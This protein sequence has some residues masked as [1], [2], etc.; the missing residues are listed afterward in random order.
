MKKVFQA[1]GGLLIAIVLCV[2]TFAQ[3]QA[4]TGLIQGT[5]V[6]PNGAVVQGATVTVKNTGTGFERSATSN[7]D[8]FFSLPLLPLGKYRVTTEAANFSKAVVEGLEVNVGQTTNLKIEL[9][10]GG[11]TQTVDIRAEGEGVEIS[12][13]ELN[14]LINEKSVEGLPINR[15]DFSRFAQLTP[16]VSIVQGPDGDEIT[17]NGQKG[18]Q[19]NLSIDGADAN[20]PFFGEQ[21]GGQRPAFTISLES[22][23]EFQVVPVGA[24]AEFGRSSG[25]FINV[26]TKSGTNEFTGSAFLYFK[27]QGLSSQNPD[28]V[29]ARLPVE[30]FRNYQ[31]GANIGG[32]I[33]TDKAFFFLAY[34]RNDGISRKPNS[35]DATLR[36]IF[37]TRFNSPNEQTTIERTNDADVFLGKVDFQINNNNLLTMRHNFSRAEQVNGTF[38]VPT[39][40]ASANGRETSKSNS[41]IASLVT[42]FSSNLLNEFRFQYAKEERPRFYDGPDLPDVT[43]GTFAGDISYRFGRPFFLPVPSD[44]MRLQF[45]NNFTVIRGNHTIKFGADINRV[46]VSQTFIGF[47]RGRYIFA[48]ATIAG[49]IAGFQNYINGTSAAALQLY[50]QFAPIG[51]RTVEQ[52]GTQSYNVFEPG[53]YVQ[54][55]WQVRPNLTL[56][57]GFRWEGQY[58]PDPI[59]P[60]SATRYGQFVNDPRFPSTGAIP[61]F[62]DGYQP[63]VGLSWSPGKDGKTAIRLGAGLYYARIPGLVVAGPRNTDGAI[64]GN[65]FFANFLCGG[66]GLGGCPVFPGVVPTAGFTPFNPGIAVFSRDFK[67]PRTL[68]YSVSVERELV[69]DLNLTVAYNYAKSTRL[70]T[71]I[72]R[73]DGRLY[74]GG[75]SP[76]ERANGSGVGEIRSTESIGKSLFQGLTLGLTKRFSNRFQFQANYLLSSDKSS[77]D[78]ERDPFTF[79]YAD[80]RNLTPEYGYS[81]RDQRHRF[82][83]FAVFNLPYD[84]NLSPIFQYRSA[85]PTSVTNRGTFPNIVQRNTLRLNNEFFTFDFRASKLFKFTEKMSLEAIFDAFN[86]TN[87][88]NQ[89]S[90]PRPLTFNFD[91]TVTAGFG[92]PRQAQLGVRF[93][94]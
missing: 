9:K 93:K 34:E 70:T 20:N 79:R 87:S 85:Q 29:A 27:N 15:R 25:G 64:A 91:G 4:T 28:A 10:V 62:K 68:Q 37:A 46:N 18:I 80:P 32:P 77:D 44:D 42:N 83:A 61:D 16:G 35:I 90:L 41:F 43:I 50:L 33:K 94:F 75:V 14:T 21:R 72:N 22:V 58:Q 19:N 66:A 57:L 60:A 36:N 88:R 3:S 65:I 6:D 26:V 53:I 24:S 31:V 30:D 86:L 71:F 45:T 54:D 47:A 92:E 11:T 84:I 13:T 74:A 5:V 81:D 73:G 52:A 7:S 67:N 82:N 2:P 38:D 17:I 56:N 48:D 55:N 59:N 39:W 76:F 89:R 1:F 8:G 23:K 63:R 40:G 51:N 69:K 78:N 49:A 12:R